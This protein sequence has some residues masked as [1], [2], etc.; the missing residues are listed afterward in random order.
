MH[1][2]G[3]APTP[4]GGNGDGKGA[5]VNSPKKEPCGLGLVSINFRNSFF[6][7]FLLLACAEVGLPWQ[8]AFHV[9]GTDGHQSH[10]A[11]IDTPRAA[12]LSEIEQLGRD[13]KPS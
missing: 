11:A 3:S 8:P 1:W 10:R 5:G 7:F 2:V 13:H 4:P 9:I 6:F 12:D